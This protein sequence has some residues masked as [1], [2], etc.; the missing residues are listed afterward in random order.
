MAVGLSM[1]F[2]S[3]ICVISTQIVMKLVFHRLG[4]MSLDSGFGAYLLRAM[5]EPLVWLSGFT[6]IGGALLWYMALS[7][8]PLSTIYPFTALSYPL[9]AVA[10]WAIL[11]EQITVLT[12]VGTGL[13]TIGVIT[14]FFG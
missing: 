12:L 7:R 2:G 5:A 6:L 13:I 8:L 10:S 14:A 4:I 3:L 11:G 9:I 1:V